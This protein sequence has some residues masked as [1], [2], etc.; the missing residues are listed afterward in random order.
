MTPV[1]IVTGAGR[2]IGRSEAL[3]LAA[4]GYAVVVNDLGGSL[5]GEG[6]SADVA[7]SVVAEIAEAGG[8][9]VAHVGDVSSPDDVE[10]MLDVAL[11]SFGRVDCLVNNAGNLPPTRIVCDMSLDELDRAL[12]VHVR[13]HFATTIALTRHWRNEAR[14]TGEPVAAS[15]VNTASEAYLFGSPWRPDYAASKAAIV[16]LTVGTALS[17]A[18]F[19][20][21]VNAICP[22]AST[23]M[24]EGMLS[25]DAP[26]RDPRH[27]ADLV[28]AL[29]GTP[30]VN[31]QVFVVGPG[32]V[33]VLAGPAVVREFAPEDED[34]EGGADRVA[35]LLEGYF[36]TEGDVPAY[37]TPLGR[38]ARYLENLHESFEIR[39]R[40]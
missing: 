16:S 36:G 17:C 28:V 9:A 35:S 3:A 21:R 15:I 11:T 29:C 14:R 39:A 37:G 7:E 13:G 34:A 23:R 1:A 31:G 8:T 20:V 18:P 2:G 19:G 12:R 38:T 24:T 4:A 27:T 22:R 10:A 26:A 25:G 33:Q 40:D 30:S 5:A 32:V 6:S